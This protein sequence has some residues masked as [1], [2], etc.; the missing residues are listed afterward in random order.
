MVAEAPPPEA[1]RYLYFEGVSKHDSL[2][3]ETMKMLYRDEFGVTRLER[4]HKPSWLGRF[5]DD[6]CF[7]IDAVKAPVSGSERAIRQAIHARLDEVIAEIRELQPDG[8]LVVKQIVWEALGSSLMTARLPV[9]N[10]GPLMF[11]G[12]S[13]QSRFHA[14]VE[15]LGI[16]EFVRGRVDTH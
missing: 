13:Q 4:R 10:E 9:L 16:R 15:R 2:W 1:S 11:P 5:R 7:L 6:G 3:L 8:V 14:E 12:S